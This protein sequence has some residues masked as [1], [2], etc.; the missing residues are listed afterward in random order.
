M[1][2]SQVPVCVHERI[3]L[4]LAFAQMSS[5]LA[6]DA[7]RLGHELGD[8]VVVLLALDRQLL[9]LGLQARKLLRIG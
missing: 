2:L 4:F 9:I 3:Q 6:L 7:L 8:L 1:L 5:H